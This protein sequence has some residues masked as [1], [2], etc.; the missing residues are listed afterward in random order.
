VVLP[1]I[2]VAL[3]C[4]AR[5]GR[6]MTIPALSVWQLEREQRVSPRAVGALVVGVLVLLYGL[7][8]LLI[9]RRM[10]GA[11]TADLTWPVLFAT[12]LA[13]FAIITGTRILWRRAFPEPTML[14]NWI[15]W[16]ASLTLV[17]LAAGLSFPGNR[18]S[19]SWEREWL[20]WLPLLIADQ[21]LRWKLFDTPTSETKDTPAACRLSGNEVQQIV[22]TRDAS[23]HEMVRATLRADFQ[24]GQRTATAYIGF[25]P[26][27]AAVPAIT[28]ESASDST[29]ELKIVQAY[30]HGARIDVRLA[31]V[32]HESTSVVLN[33]VAQ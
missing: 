25:C 17:L 26:P 14:D 31:Q 18:F 13:A 20:I 15:G 29:A 1:L 8:L 3:N 10:M 32:A 19:A 23:G 22:R 24:P 2:I 12:A 28:V 6:D 7:S 9:T 4:N 11:F 5:Y 30:A 16:G 27:L 33:L 21:V